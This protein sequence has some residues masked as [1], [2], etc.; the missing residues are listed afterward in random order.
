[1]GFAGIVGRKIEGIT[2]S[3]AFKFQRDQFDNM[4]DGMGTGA[5]GAN[6]GEPGRRARDDEPFPISEVIGLR[7]V[8]R[9]TDNRCTVFL[10]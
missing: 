5:T 4:C 6:N 3:G 10:N 9:G 2:S 7:S 8:I 1:M